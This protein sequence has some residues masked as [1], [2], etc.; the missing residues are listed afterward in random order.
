MTDPAPAPTVAPTMEGLWLLG[1]LC[2]GA[3]ASVAAWLTW[4]VLSR[5]TFS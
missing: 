1:G 5:W 2:T 4:A 3:F